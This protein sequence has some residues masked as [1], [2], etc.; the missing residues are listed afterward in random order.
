[1]NFLIFYT[2]LGEDHIRFYRDYW[3]LLY[4]IV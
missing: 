4:I 2:F 3:K 1:M